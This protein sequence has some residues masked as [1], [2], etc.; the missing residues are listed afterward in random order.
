MTRCLPPPAPLARGA[1]IRELQETL[2]VMGHKVRIREGHDVRGEAD[3]LWNP[4]N[5]M[6][7]A[8]PALT[9]SA[10]RQRAGRELMSLTPLLQH[11]RTR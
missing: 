10:I 6:R 5:R 1:Q 8:R 9:R 4:S 7:Q 3:R 2:D 11:G